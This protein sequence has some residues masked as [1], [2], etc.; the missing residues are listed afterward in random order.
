LNT[1][2]A[3]GKSNPT[4]T[5]IAAILEALEISV[6]EFEAYYDRITEKDIAKY[7]KE[8]EKA[9]KERTKKK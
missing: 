3:S 8:I 6:S 2:Q 4:G 5:T 7:K 9:R 1:T